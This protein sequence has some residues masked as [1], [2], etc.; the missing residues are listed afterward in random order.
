MFIFFYKTME[1]SGPTTLCS[2]WAVKR[3]TQRSLAGRLAPNWKKR[4]LILSGAAGPASLQW[5]SDEPA[6][7][8]TL[9]GHLDLSDGTSVAAARPGEDV[10]LGY[11][12]GGGFDPR[13]GGAGIV[14]EDPGAGAKRMHFLVE[15][16]AGASPASP[17]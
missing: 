3:S 4:F 6:K 10:F 7:G 11:K 9:K 12:T 13:H 1:S 15:V 14:I 8:G 5:W 17:E 16:G 2:G